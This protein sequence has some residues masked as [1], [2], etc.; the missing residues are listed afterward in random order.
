MCP[1]LSD[2]SRLTLSWEKISC[3]VETRYHRIGSQLSEA[4]DGRSETKAE[5]RSGNVVRECQTLSGQ[6]RG[7]IGLSRPQCAVL[8]NSGYPSNYSS[9][10]QLY[11]EIR[12]F[13]NSYGLRERHRDV[14]YTRFT[15]TIRTSAET[16]SNC[17]QIEG[18]SASEKAWGTRQ[19]RQLVSVRSV[20]CVSV[21]LNSLR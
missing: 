1:V 12:Q 2:F 4:E 7:N 10:A 19:I 6:A 15:Y 20:L 8:P 3:E 17:S 16:L 5:R 21:S 11:S 14:L 18:G 9:T 13:V